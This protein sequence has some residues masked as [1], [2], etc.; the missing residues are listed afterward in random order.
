MPDIPAVDIQLDSQIIAIICCI[1]HYDPSKQLVLACIASPYRVGS[2]LSHGQYQENVVEKPIAF[3]SRSLS[4][5]GKNYSHLEKR[6][7]SDV[8]CKT[9]PSIP[10]CSSFRDTFRSLTPKAIA[11][12]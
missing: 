1:N 5:A 6:N 10:V 9:L 11:T 8:L 3:A 12:Y 7:G 4:K 2:V